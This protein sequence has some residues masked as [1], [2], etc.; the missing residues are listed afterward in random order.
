MGKMNSGLNAVAKTSGTKSAKQKV[1][2]PI[3]ANVKSSGTNPPLLVQ[4]KA[5]QGAKHGMTNTPTKV[6]K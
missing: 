3:K 5:N 2:K 1:V 6:T 4:K